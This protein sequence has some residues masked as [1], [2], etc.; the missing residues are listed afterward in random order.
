VK[1]LNRKKHNQGVSI[2]AAMAI[3]LIAS[4]LTFVMASMLGRVSRRALD[5]LRSAQA[6][7]IAQGGLNWYMM[8]LASDTNWTTLP[9]G[10]NVP[11]G[12]GTF[13]VTTSSATNPETDSTGGTSVFFTVTGNVPG[14]GS[15]TI[16]RTMSQ[17]AWQL[18]SASKFAL[19]WGRDTSRTL[20]L[21]STT[22]NGDYW[23]QGSSTLTSSTVSSPFNLYYPTGKTITYSGTNKVAVGAFPYF[24]NLNGGASFTSTLSTPAITATYWTTLEST[25]DAIISACTAT[26][27]WTLNSNYALS[28]TVCYGTINT[29]TSNSTNVTISGNGFIVANGNMRL[30]ASASNATR[31]LTISPSGGNIVFLAKGGL[32]VGN[33]VSRVNA[34]TTATA[35]IRMYTNSASGSSYWFTITGS[36]VNMNSGGSVNN[37]MLILAKRRLYVLSGAKIY[38]ATLF[39]DYPGNTT[40]NVLY[41]NGS[42]TSVGWTTAT[43]PSCPCSVISMAR[44]TVSTIQALTINGAASVAGLV[45]QYDS[46]NTGYTLIN[47]ASGALTNIKGTVIANQFWTMG[48]SGYTTTITYDPTVIPDPPPEGF[49]GFATKEPNSW[50]GS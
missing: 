19:F 45:Y 35:G 24:S 25:Y 41:I 23:S 46:A 4:V 5:S 3:I 18:P 12:N 34:T 2:V 43:C 47:S 31:I 21:T 17:S 16:Q 13:T 8:Q 33:G 28:G 42:G 40:N 27:T 11:L 6:F 48:A 26:T 15:A 10:S 36:G 38:D 22:I 1:S 50:S 7:A 44:G 37:K 32:T 39:V 49:G 9:T 14:T 20:T 29:N 30:N